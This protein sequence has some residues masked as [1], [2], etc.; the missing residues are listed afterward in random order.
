V[1]VRTRLVLAFTYIIVVVVIAFEV[2]LAINLQRRTIADVKSQAIQDAL[3]IAAQTGAERTQRPDA[4]QRWVYKNFPHDEDGRVIVVDPQGVLIADSLGPDNLGRVYAT[5]GRP[6]LGRVIDTKQPTSE[7]RYS[8]TLQQELLVAAAPILDEGTFFGAVRRSQGMGEVQ[9]RVRRVTLG[10]V[11]IGLAALLAGLIIAFALSGSL[12]RP[13]SRLAAAA[14]RLGHGDLS[15]RTDERAGASEIVELSGAFDDMADRLEATVKAQHEFIGNAS[16]QLRT[17]LTGMKLRIESAMEAAGSAEERR[18]LEAADKEVDRLAEIVERLLVMARRIEQG[19]AAEVDLGEIV[20]SAVER[21]GERASRLGASLRT[22]GEGGQALG[23]RADIDQI[24]DNLIDNAISHAPGPI[25]VE[26]GRANGRVFL[27]VEDRGSGI[28][29]DEVHRVTERFFRGRG[30]PSGGSGLGLA[31]VRELAEKW[32]GSVAITSP[33]EGGTRV[34]VR[35]EPA[36]TAGQ[37]AP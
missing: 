24:L 27:A 28:A 20:S 25:V 17:P 26:S 22:K 37:S 9:S 21:W 7:I 18:Q 6:E 12:S 10:L 5:S 15:V 30:A 3:L 4:L 35:L 19:G 11:V 31:I 2:P 36:G 33:E 23:D 14:M 13:L 34:E 16:H 32:G 29:P 8:T 1:K